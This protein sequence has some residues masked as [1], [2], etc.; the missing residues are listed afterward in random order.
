MHDEAL[1][2]NTMGAAEK[3]AARIDGPAYAIDN[4]TA[5]KLTDGTVE[6]VLEGRWR[7]FP[8]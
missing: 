5:I 6:V 2:T 3:W 8:P 4:E 7:F 1:P